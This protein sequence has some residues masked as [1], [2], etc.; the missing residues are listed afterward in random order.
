[1]SMLPDEAMRTGVDYAE[2]PGSGP[3]YSHS[4]ID[5]VS[6]IREP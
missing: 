5:S 4:W 3:L 1:M 6:H 2:Y